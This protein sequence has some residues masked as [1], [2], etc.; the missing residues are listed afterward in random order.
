M[1]LAKW[2]FALRGRDVGAGGG[3]IVRPVLR[4]DQGLWIQFDHTRK[5]LVIRPKWV[6][7]W[8]Q[9]RETT[10]RRRI[11]RGPPLVVAEH[12]KARAGAITP[13]PS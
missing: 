6:R 12:G 2:R 9:T 8:G 7:E 5:G 4:S 3:E 10:H 13:G 11:A 1:V